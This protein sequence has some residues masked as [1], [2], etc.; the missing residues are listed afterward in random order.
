M[1]RVE[2]LVDSGTLELLPETA[3]IA[4]H[5]DVYNAV[6]IGNTKRIWPMF[7]NWLA[8]Q[9]NDLTNPFDIFIETS[10]PRALDNCFH[11]DHE[12]KS[13]ELFWSNGK[14]QKVCREI[15]PR[16]SDDANSSEGKDYHCYDY[17]S[18][19]FLVS[20][21]RIAVTTGEYWHDTA[22]TKLCVHPEYGTWTAFRTVVVF[23]TN[24]NTYSIP[25]M[26]KPCPCPVS[27]EEIKK[28]KNIFDYALRLSSSD[29]QGYGTTLDKSW[30]ELSKYLHNTVC[31]GS[32]WDQVPKSMKPWIQLRDVI[33]VGRD[34]WK[35]DDAQ[36]LYHYTKD[37]AILTRELAKLQSC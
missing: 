31:S 4:D 30:A 25:D 20:M 14:R 27:N 1:I 16:R 21:Q 10:L 34:T 19:S 9:K 32:D 29:E 13:Y 26:P 15:D 37:P 23:E 8:E 12:L 3:T 5:G 2:G 24:S 7:L 6:L 28:A 18:A 36:L 11:D 33:G 22:A 35:Y 17:K